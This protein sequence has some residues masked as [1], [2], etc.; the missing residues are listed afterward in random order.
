MDTTN[1]SSGI[2]VNEICSWFK[3][4][5]VPELDEERVAQLYFAFHPRT[6]FLKTLRSGSAVVDIGAGD[7]S[8][9]VFRSWP[10]PVRDDLR[11]YAYSIE[12]GRL[13]DD[14]SGYEISDWNVNPPQFDGTQFDAVVCAHFIEHI[15]DPVSLVRWAASKL[16][17]GGRIYLE[18]P[19]ADSLSLP[20][21]TELEERGV[22][23][24][25]SRFDDDD[26]H[27]ALPDGDVIAA[28]LRENG[29]SI[30]ARGIVRLPWLEDEMLAH[31]KQSADGFYGQAAFWSHTGWC[32][33]IVAE[34]ARATDG[35]EP[36]R[37]PV[38]LAPTESPQATEGSRH[39]LATLQAEHKA[40]ISHARA[41]EKKLAEVEEL[42]A[43]ERELFAQHP[44]V[45]VQELQRAA[46][47]NQEKLRLLAE[48]EEENSR[49]LADLE[50]LRRG[51]ELML[52]SR[53]WKLTAPLRALSGRLRGR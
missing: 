2:G 40:S 22:P 20:S 10:E 52:N 9:S 4:E 43:R 49:L 50:S 42:L 21:R 17:S 5:R 14:F 25:I 46:A 47:D 30:E 29:F 45:L 28:A 51:H 13:F 53:S 31:H 39:R 44:D 33:Y 16:K 36:A 1:R 15:Q 6:V 23:L 11:M 18:W 7:G 24:I 37:P 27:Q 38:R 3:R 41:L 34:L 12:K 35:R 19:S 32:Q 8:L 48:K 26:T